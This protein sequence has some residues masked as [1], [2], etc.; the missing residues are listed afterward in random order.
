M[1]DDAV[2][3]RAIVAAMLC[4]TF[5]VAACGAFSGT[6]DAP[7]AASAPDGGVLADGAVAAEGASPT[8]DAAGD[9]AAACASPT[10]ATTTGCV[11]APFTTEPPPPWLPNGNIAVDADGLLANSASETTYRYPDATKDSLELIVEL[12][13]KVE[14]VGAN[15]RIGLASFVGPA[16]T[17]GGDPDELFVGVDQAG[18][19]AVCSAPGGVSSGGGCQKTSAQLTFGAWH[20]LRWHV[21]ATG[22]VMAA[23]VALD[24]RA[25]QIVQIATPVTL[26]RPPAGALDFHVGLTTVDGAAPSPAKVHV[27]NVYRLVK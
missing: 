1:Y 2:G 11:F 4:G 13:V 22:A 27:K 17:S 15:D 19:V 26:A 10:C 21:V 23:D 16:P 6:E 18:T 8:P 3:A 25:P 5:A 20:H 7:P 24:C 9:G 12:D 14:Q